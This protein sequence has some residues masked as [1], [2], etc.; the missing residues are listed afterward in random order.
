MATKQRL[1]GCFRCTFGVGAAA[2]LTTGIA[3][4]GRWR[5]DVAVE[6]VDYGGDVLVG[7]LNERHVGGVLGH[8]QSGIS[9]VN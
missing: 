3:V 2:S 9:H 8:K 6:E 4:A 1:G 5:S 7:L